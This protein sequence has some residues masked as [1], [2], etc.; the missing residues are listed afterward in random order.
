MPERTRVTSGEYRETARTGVAPSVEQVREHAN[1]FRQAQSWGEL[2]G[3][4]HTF[5]FALERKG[6]G[7]VITDGQHEVK[8]SRVHRDLS[9]SRLEERLG[10]VEPREPH[11]D[12]SAHRDRAAQVHGP[13][14]ARFRGVSAGNEVPGSDRL[15]EL[16]DLV[17]Q[18]ERAQ[19][20]GTLH[21]HVERD[22]HG[23]ASGLERLPWAEGRARATSK[24]F[25]RALARV[26]AWPA[27][28]RELFDH[29]VRTAGLSAA[30][31]RMVEQPR[32]FGELRRTKRKVLWGLVPVRDTREATTHV[33]AAAARGWEA[34]EAA[35]QL[36]EWVHRLAP[37]GIVINGRE[38]DAYVHAVTHQTTRLQHAE[39]R[40]AWVHGA[41]AAFRDRRSLER[42]IG[43]A[44]V[45]LAPRAVR[46]L[47]LLLTDPQRAIMDAAVRLALDLA[48][49]RG[50]GR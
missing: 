3:R 2:H 40:L 7:F 25:D 10:P 13:E 31:D 44:V 19:R 46:Q 50:L 27:D 34:T 22:R 9:F 16:T 17:R 26:Y 37:N 11:P 24:E 29:A 43:H 12:I 42:D 39:Q 35:G 23:A 21:Y 6:Q 20:L 1:W 36:K 5:G 32:A 38:T 30:R 47:A 4:L 48:L 33:P 45:Q 41:R 18:A 28:A 49:G 14:T 8:A 15:A